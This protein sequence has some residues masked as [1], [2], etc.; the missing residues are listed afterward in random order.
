MSET[1]S[2]PSVV[3]DD[4]TRGGATQRSV[5]SVVLLSA[6]LTVDDAEKDK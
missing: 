2:L 6:E 5:A 4:T 1:Y 3:D